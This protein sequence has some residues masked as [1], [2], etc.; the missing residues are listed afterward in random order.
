M[1]IAISIFAII[2]RMLFINI[3]SNDYVDFLEP[4]FNV[5][6]TN[7]GLAGI[8]YYNG[9]YN[10]SYITIMALLTYL[11]FKPVFSIKAISILFDYILAITCGKIVRQFFKSEKNANLYAVISYAIVLFI[12]TV[13]LNGSF[14]GQCDSIYTA[15][16]MMA[17]LSLIKEKYFRAFVFLRNIIC[18]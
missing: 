5:L 18:I 2:V 11:P 6:K 10:Y 3:E 12:P 9:D 14:W 7:G 1:F 17:I 8:K 15:F 13:L 4:W 16:A